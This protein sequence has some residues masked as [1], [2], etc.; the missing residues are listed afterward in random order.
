MKKLLCKKDILGKRTGIHYKVG[1]IYEFE[2]KKLMRLL[3]S[4]FK[5]LKKKTKQMTNLLV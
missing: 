5:R 1:E 2:E 4:I 3:E